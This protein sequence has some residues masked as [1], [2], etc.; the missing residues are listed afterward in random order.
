[1]EITLNSSTEHQNESGATPE[2]IVEIDGNQE[3]KSGKSNSELMAE[4]FSVH[5]EADNK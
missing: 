4:F 3:N 5:S 1:M 2:N